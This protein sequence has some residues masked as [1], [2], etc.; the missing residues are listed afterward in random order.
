[1]SEALDAR[2][3][4]RRQADVVAGLRR[5]PAARGAERRRRQ[6]R[7]PARSR[8]A[9]TCAASELDPD[10]RHLLHLA[11]RRIL[12]ACESCVALRGGDPE[13]RPD[14]APGPS[15][16]T[17]SSSPTSSGRRS[18]SRSGSPSSSTRA[19]RAGSSR[20][21]RARPGR[22]SPSSTSRPGTSSAPATRCSMG[23]EPDAEALIVNRIAEPP[24]HAIAPIDECYRLVGLIKA[25]WDGISGGAGPERAIEAFFGELR[26]RRGGVS[27]ADADAARRSSAGPADA[28][29]TGRRR[30]SPARP[31]R[32]SRSS[33]PR[34]VERAA[35]PTL[36]LPRAGSATSSG[37]ALFTIALTAVI[38]IEP[39]EAPLRR[40]RAA[41]GWSSC[42]A[43]PSAGPRPPTS[44]RWA[45]ADVLVPGV[46]GLDRV[47]AR[48]PLHLRPRA[49]RG[50]V[51]PR[52]RR[53]RGAAAL[54]LQRHRLLRGRRRAD[55]DRP[56]PVGPLAALRA[57][58][59][60]SGGGR[61]TPLYPYRALGPG[62]PRDARAAASAARPSAGCRPSTRSLDELLDD[63]EG[64]R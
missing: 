8:S 46:R 7:P 54:P 11:E 43:S 58:R 28:P 24:E 57:C 14:R 13:L 41:S 30:P 20:S 37:P 1:M 52:A 22:P 50:Q 51:L 63:E 36:A 2:V 6:R 19:P 16:S 27:D 64:E 34:A 17:T 53:R 21:T 44:F 23:L 15:G 25:S 42:S 3:A 59:S 12:C 56:D 10:H 61:S 32:S 31:I 38:S 26:E 33:A 39:V 45:Q 60:R 29:P 35:A 55:A 47:R 48:R 4:A 62:R 5:L 18:R 9:A 49:R 40:R